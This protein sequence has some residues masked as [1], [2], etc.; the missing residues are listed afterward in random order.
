MKRECLV[1]RVFG[2][3]TVVSDAPD[4]LGRYLNCICVCGSSK[5]VAIGSIRS[6]ISQSCGCLNAELS[7]ER[8][9]THG[10]SGTRTYNIWVSMKARCLNVQN[11]A[12]A[13]YGKRGIKV[14]ERWMTFE[15][16]RDD[17]G[18]CPEGMSIDRVDNNKGYEPTN[19]KWATAKTQ[20]NNKR[21]NR[22]YKVDGNAMTISQI[23]EMFGIEYWMLRARLVIL[24]WP[25][26]RAI[27]E[28]SRQKHKFHSLT[29]PA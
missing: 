2:R 28:P 12:Y 19:C 10:V 5:E 11:H 16:F 14:C 15:N 8:R 26:S 27:S 25:V 17:M 21:T 4:R 22:T 18:E 24:K 6:G 3:W 9:T 7:S 13:N 1:G 23:S 20:A 29:Q